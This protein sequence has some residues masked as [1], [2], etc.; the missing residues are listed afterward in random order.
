METVFI[1]KEIIYLQSVESTN[2]YA[3]NLL[4][5]VNFKEGT[6][7]FAHH[8]TKGKG[9]RGKV[10]NTQQG[11]NLTV[12]I[13]L[14]PEFLAIEKLFFLYQITALACYD[15]LAEIINQSQNDIKIKWAN[16][17]LI[18]NKK[19][20]GILIENIISENKISHSVIG[21][22]LNV[23]QI[24]FG[25][26]TKATSIK[27][28]TGN[29]IEI[30]FILNRVCFHL[31]KRYEQLKEKQFDVIQNE[32]LKNLY[33]LNEKINFI[34]KSNSRIFEIIGISEFGL[35]SLKDEIG[36]KLE[37]DIGELKWL[38]D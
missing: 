17:I 38:L 2:S 26:R 5:K 29:E 14:K 13:I 18:D 28:I 15:C 1:G 34:F 25:E 31:E 20:A 27:N 12:S 37:C 16:D 11:L 21:I 32:Y 10:W 23:N 33:G 19:I 22:G 35:L 6:V 9:Q 24:E 7:V 8:Q 4:R 3:M 30:K 36:N